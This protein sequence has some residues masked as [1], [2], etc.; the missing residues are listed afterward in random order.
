MSVHETYRNCIVVKLHWNCIF[1]SGLLSVLAFQNHL[2]YK[3]L[4]GKQKVVENVISF[5]FGVAHNPFSC[6]EIIKC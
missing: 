2:M 1:S 4:E 6:N 5:V 3:H